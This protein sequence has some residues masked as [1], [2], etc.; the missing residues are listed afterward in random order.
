[1]PRRATVT[2][3]SRSLARLRSSL[4]DRAL[5]FI[6]T[7]KFLSIQLDITN[8]CNLTC[9][10]CYHAHHSNA[11]AL[12]FD[13]WKAILDQYA[14]LLDKLHL[15]PWFRICGGEPTLS[16][17]LLPMLEEINFRWPGVRVGMMT[18]GT[19]LSRA[20]VA[21]LKPF[22]PHIQ[23]S[24]DGPDAERHDL[25]R[26]RGVFAQ[27]LEGLENW[28]AAGLTAFFSA[29][30]SHRTSFWIDDFFETARRQA[31]ASMSFARFIAQG[32][33]KVLVDSRVDRA[34]TPA[35]LREA[36]ARILDVSRSSGVPTSTDLPLFQL[37]DSRLGANGKGGFQG[38]VVDYKGYLKVSSRTD[39]VL[40]S[41]LLEG[42]EDLFL[43]HPT[44]T[45]LRQRDIEG[46]GCCRHYSHCGGDR[47]ASFAATG[48]FLK[49]DPGCWL[50]LS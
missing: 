49:K 31:A 3:V 50:E 12:S 40:G 1:M 43:R 38:L 39:F 11:G 37:V 42:L 30:L 16:P 7:Q 44:M 4:L 45:A 21:D 6:G 23:I 36:Y 24:L 15:R 27:T 18:N 32:T 35:E 26:G 17:L 34:L 8:A 25:I 33:G 10:H 48:S 29:T 9:A 20:L 22:N 41:V 47:N 28:R 46:C 13:G 14:G 19:R 2:R 5:R